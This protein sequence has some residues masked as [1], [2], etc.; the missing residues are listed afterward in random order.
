MLNLDSV[1]RC[2]SL[3]KLY[4]T[5][6]NPLSANQAF[7]VRYAAMPILVASKLIPSYVLPCLSLPPLYGSD[8]KLSSSVQCLCVTWPNYAVAMTR[9]SSALPNETLLHVAFAV[10]TR[11]F[12]ALPILRISL[13]KLHV[14]VAKHVGA[15]P[16]LSVAM[17]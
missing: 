6:Q 16:L 8:T 4:V 13:A 2:S 17:P 14:A 12:K 7:P 9:F 15:I 1:I 11:L 5:E 10:Y 3:P